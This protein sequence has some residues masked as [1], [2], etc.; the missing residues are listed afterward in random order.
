MDI[1]KDQE[2]RHKKILIETAINGYTIRDHGGLSVIEEKAG[3][4]ADIDA[5]AELLR[6]IQM[7]LGYGCDKH[8]ERVIRV[9]ITPGHKFMGKISD[10]YKKSLEEIKSD[11]E[12]FLGAKNG[13]KRKNQIISKSERGS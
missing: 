5:V 7:S 13:T 6:E 2:Q 11:I 12:H 10:Q 4:D 1:E 8:G 3:V 9:I